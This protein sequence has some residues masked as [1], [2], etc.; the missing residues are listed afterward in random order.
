MPG[1]AHPSPPRKLENPLKKKAGEMQPYQSEGVEGSDRLASHPPKKKQ[2]GKKSKNC[3][4]GFFFK[5]GRA[6]GWTTCSPSSRR[7]C[8]ILPCTTCR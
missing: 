3:G 8:F 5:W 6:G 7:R 1:I 4:P 2:E